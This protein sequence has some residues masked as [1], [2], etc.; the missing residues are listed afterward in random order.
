MF[1][2]V[3]G[4]ATMGISVVEMEDADVEIGRLGSQRELFECV[5]VST[6]IAF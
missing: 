1:A 2:Y 4:A 6:G 3:C 5:E